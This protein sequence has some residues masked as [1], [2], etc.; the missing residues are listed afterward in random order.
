M[1]SWLFWNPKVIKKDSADERY[2]AVD[3]YI[4]IVAVEYY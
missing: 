2:V 4:T 1:K 3:L